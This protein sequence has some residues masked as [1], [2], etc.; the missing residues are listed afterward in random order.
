[1]P[2]TRALAMDPL[3]R[4]SGLDISF[5]GFPDPASFSPEVGERQ[6]RAA[7]RETNDDPVPRRLSLYLHVPF[8]EQPCFHCP[9]TFTVGADSGKVRAYF[10]RLARECEL[11]APLFDRDRDVIQLKVGGGGPSKIDPAALGEL[12]YAASRHFFLSRGRE[13]EFMIELPVGEHCAEEISGFAD[14]GFN[15]ARFTVFDFEGSTEA[16]L[17][18][19][20]VQAELAAAVEDAR[21]A[22]FR[23]ICFDALYGLPGRSDTDLLKWLELL[24]EQRPD[25]IS[26]HPF[27]GRMRLASAAS[28]PPVR[29]L[30]E[31]IG[32]RAVAVRALLAAGYDPIGLDV[33]ALPQDDLSRVRRSGQ[34]HRNALG[35]TPHA[36]TDLIGLGVS[37]QSRIGD[38]CFQNQ[39][40]LPAWESA[41]DMGELPIWRGLWMDADARLRSDLLHDLLCKGEVD[42]AVLEARHEVDF[43]VYF[44]TELEALAPL[45]DGDL[46]SF[47]GRR[48]RVSEAG[49][50]SLRA[51][52]EPFA[53]MGKRQRWPERSASL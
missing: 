10:D 48:L 27:G 11:A 23:S 18:R 19:R 30:G 17:Q 4:F 34:L 53:R 39:V 43:A 46:V 41:V 49:R 31:R 9:G 37:A 33:F 3:L 22:G 40:D 5:Q 2:T 7:A 1:M 8:A 47:D 16:L 38:A 36:E 51:I 50:L 24:L 29:A 25:R 6:L 35:Y 20:L 26:L 15:R 21:T 52:A 14:L 42:S 12:L 45:C 13:R 32:Q 28:G 44:Q